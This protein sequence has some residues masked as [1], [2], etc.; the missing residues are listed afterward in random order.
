MTN[1]KWKIC[2]LILPTADCPFPFPHLPF[3]LSPFPLFPSSPSLGAL[4]A[5]ASTA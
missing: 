1:E 4:A 3:T 5:T 2:F